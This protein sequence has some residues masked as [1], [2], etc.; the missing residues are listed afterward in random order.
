MRHRGYIPKITA[1]MLVPV[2]ALATL[3]V[4]Y[5]HWRE[6]LQ[7]TGTINT[8]KW[9][10]SIGSSKVVKP[11]GYDEN[12][13]IEDE[14]L[15]D[16]RTLQL[17]CK[18]VSGGWHIWVGLIIQNDGTVPTSVEEPNIQINHNQEGFTIKT[19]FYGPYERGEHIEV[20]GGVKIDDL[21]FEPWEDAVNLNPGQKAVIWIEFECISKEELNIVEIQIT[22]DYDLAV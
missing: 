21:P 15:P 1:L 5:S 18:N 7:I 4:T 8:G 3:G 14:I 19:Y 2:I 6:T 13:P 20:W 11:V 12:H 17:R 9:H 10:Q 16:G 22:I